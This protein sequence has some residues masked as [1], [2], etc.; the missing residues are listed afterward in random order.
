MTPALALKQ[1]YVM[2]SVPA[3]SR[4]D[5]LGIAALATWRSER[6]NKTPLLYDIGG[7]RPRPPGKK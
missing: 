4:D 5:N 2:Q 1:V 3:A 6:P 7:Q